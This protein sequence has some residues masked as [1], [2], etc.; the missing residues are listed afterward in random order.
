MK[1]RAIS[2]GLIGAFFCAITLSVSPQLHER[3]HPDAKQGQHECAATFIAA[4]NYHH[5]AVV[6]LISAPVPTVQFAKIPALTPQWVESP[7]LSSAIFEHAP[8]AQS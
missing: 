1:Q 5:T 8:P 7:F 4:G 2:I 3:F 6:P